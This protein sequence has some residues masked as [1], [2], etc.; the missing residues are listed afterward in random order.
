MNM[1]QFST[2]LSALHRDSHIAFRDKRGQWKQPGR[3]PLIRGGWNMEKAG[4][5]IEGSNSIKIEK[6][7]YND[8]YQN[9]EAFV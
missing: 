1:E 7:R 8:F 6:S 2:F 4:T 9:D 5:N 3:C